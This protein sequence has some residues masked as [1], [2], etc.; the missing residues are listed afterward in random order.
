M[1]VAPLRRHDVDD[2]IAARGAPVVHILAPGQGNPHTVPPGAMVAGPRVT[3]PAP[4]RGLVPLAIA[5]LAHLTVHNL[6]K[7][8]S[9]GPGNLSPAVGRVFLSETER[10]RKDAQ[11]HG[12]LAIFDAVNAGVK[13]IFADGAD[14]RTV[15]NALTPQI[16]AM[17]G[18]R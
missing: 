3:S 7:D 8:A 5:S 17:L 15:I 12:Y 13:P 6:V 14:P 4:P 11:F 18:G 16:N 1:R 10:G 2:R 9:D